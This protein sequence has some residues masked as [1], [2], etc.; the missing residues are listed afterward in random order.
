MKK[1]LT[2]LAIMAAIGPAWG[3]EVVSSNIVGY[4]KL[5]LQAGYNL[6][7]NN[8]NL[9]GG[10]DGNVTDVLDAKDLSGLDSQGNFT[11][12]IQIWEGDGYAFYGWAGYV[13]DATYDYKWLNQSTLEP[14]DLPAPKGTAFWIKAGAAADVTFSGEVATNETY[15]I[16][17]SAGYNLLANPFP[18]TI[19]IQQIQSENLSGL[20]AQGNFTSQLQLWEGD[21]YAFYGWAGYTGDPAY[22]YKW[23]NMSTL[24]P[25]T[26]VNIDIGTGFWIKTGSNANIDFTK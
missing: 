7:G 18:E 5:T 20:D 6:L 3:A 4:N 9:V 21:G 13:G 19:S 14:V 11:S 22:D 2:L 26:G 16:Q 17:V 12:Q 10:E 1:T 15:T 24:E 8:W 25:A 23:L